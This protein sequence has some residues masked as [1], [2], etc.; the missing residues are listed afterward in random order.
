[1]L[2]FAALL[3][4]IHVLRQFLPFQLQR[5]ILLFGA[6]LPPLYGIEGELAGFPFLDGVRLWSPFTYALLHANM[7]HVVVNVLWLIVFGSPVAWRFGTKRFIL[8]CVLLAPAGAFA[9]YMSVGSNGPAVIGASAIVSGLTAAAL[10]FVFAA[11]GVFRSGRQD[12]ER[13]KNPAPSLMQNLRDR[14]VM[15]FALIWFLLNILFGLGGALTGGIPIAWQAHLGGF[16]AGLL[17]FPLIDP[18]RKSPLS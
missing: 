13:F 1:M 16:V 10:R 6:F 5:D 2:G 17:F 4:A 11:G 15:A 3:L 7:M 12:P 14:Q 9:H 18:V 8:F